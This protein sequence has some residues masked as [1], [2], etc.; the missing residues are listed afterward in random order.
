[1]GGVR[2]SLKLAAAQTATRAQDECGVRP[3]DLLPNSR[4]TPRATRDTP[5]VCASCCAR[6]LPAPPAGSGWCMARKR[7]ME[8]L[9]ARTRASGCAEIAW[10]TVGEERLPFLKVGVSFGGKIAQRHL[11]A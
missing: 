8:R 10:A 9:S 1:M 4:R 2:R 3:V 5:Q 11:L 7:W 6:R